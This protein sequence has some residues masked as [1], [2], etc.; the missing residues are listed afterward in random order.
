MKVIVLLSFFVT[1]LAFANTYLCQSV[2]PRG[3]MAFE[4][5][6]KTPSKGRMS[7]PWTSRPEAILG[8]NEDEYNKLFVAFVNQT[9][10]EDCFTF[11]ASVYRIDERPGHEPSADSLSVMSVEKNKKTGKKQIVLKHYIGDDR[12][13]EM[14]CDKR[15]ETL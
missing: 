10:C 13:I 12:F 11:E 3:A 8:T 14:T 5:H 15:K 2:S 7:N 6:D 1:Q 4:L 9:N